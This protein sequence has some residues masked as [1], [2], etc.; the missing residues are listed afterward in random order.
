MLIVRAYCAVVTKFD[1]RKL[2]DLVLFVTNI[3]NILITIMKPGPLHCPCSGPSW[4]PSR[5]TRLS[6]GF[7]EL[8]SSHTPGV[9][10]L[11]KENSRSSTTNLEQ[12]S[13]DLLVRAVPGQLLGKVGDPLTGVGQRLRAGDQLP[14]CPLPTTDQL[15]RGRGE[16]V[17][18]FFKLC[19]QTSGA[20]SSRQFSLQLR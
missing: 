9:T 14:L 5:W 3:N 16:G 1:K 11:R 20:P 18:A 7:P 10:R 8:E 4:S 15:A 19:N 13:A 6:T 12:V 17:E 2:S